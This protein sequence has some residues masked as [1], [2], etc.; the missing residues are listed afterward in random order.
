MI[1][2]ENNFPEPEN[3]LSG[4]KPVLELLRSS[5]G[6]ADSVFIR[7]GRKD[8]VTDEIIDLCRAAGVRFSLLEERAWRRMG[9]A[10]SQGVLA[11]LFEPGFSSLE[12]AAAAALSSPLPLLLA[13]DQLLDPGNVGTL[14]RTLYSLGGGGLLLPRRRAAYLGGGANRSAAGAMQKLPVAKVAN[15]GRALDL[16]AARGFSVYGSAARK[17]DSADSR[18]GSLD[19]YSFQPRFPSVLALGSE[20]SGLRPGIAKRCARM[21]HIPM[22]RDFNSL[23]VAQAG[24]IML[25]FFSAARRR[26]PASA[27]PEPDVPEAGERGRF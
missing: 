4:P 22:C 24:G 21:L 3:A 5:P 20:E 16:L 10:G 19:V 15:L 27:D 26:A 11:R 14:A 7:K 6:R 12:E 1:A 2:A 8:R 13:L 23:N 18:G 25:A 17:E 9:A